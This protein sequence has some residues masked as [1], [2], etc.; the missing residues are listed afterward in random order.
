MSAQPAPANLHIEPGP[1][2]PGQHAPNQYAADAQYY[3]QALHEL[4]DMGTGLARLLH[5]QATTQA[6]AAPQDPGS[7]PAPV[8]APDPLISI[9]AAFDR[10]AR[11]VRRSIALA[12]SLADPVP[13]A[14][15]PAQHR[16]AARKRIL[17]DVEDAIQ[18]TAPGSGHAASDHAA[19]DG[20]GA[21]DADA[22]EA[23]DEAL[24]AELHDRLDA[25]DLDDDISS[26]P[27]AEIIT[28]ICRDLGLAALP[29]AHP[30]KRRTPADLEQLCA[31]AA[32]PSGTCPSGA[33][34]L[35]PATPQRAPTNPVPPGPAATPCATGPSHAGSGPPDDPADTPAGIATIPRH[36]THLHGQWRPPPEPE[37]TPGGPHR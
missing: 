18:R 21:D 1:Q 17:R 30:W 32:A 28:E 9:A 15:D 23:G 35:V 22:D 4:I 11:A 16:A 31:R 14:R 2:A 36:P 37:Q 26:R 13:P 8:P 12:R 10:I 20:S 24:L 29:G 25:P 19:P 3:R 5:Q 33:G 34:P 27:V 7:Q 6:H